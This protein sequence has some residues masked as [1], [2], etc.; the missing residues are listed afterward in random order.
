MLFNWN[1]STV[2]IF[3]GFNIIYI[4]SIGIVLYHARQH[5]HTV[6]IKVLYFPSNN[7]IKLFFLDFFSDL[8]YFGKT[9]LKNH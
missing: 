3:S 6:N 7:V 1:G 5:S 2:F 8:T 4:M 9:Y